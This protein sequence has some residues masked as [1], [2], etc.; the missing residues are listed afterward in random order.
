MWKRRIGGR[1]HDIGAIGVI[2]GGG[3][4]RRYNRRNRERTLGMFIIE[5]LSLVISAVIHW[6]PKNNLNRFYSLDINEKDFFMTT[7]CCAAPTEVIRVMD[8]SPL[9]ELYSYDQCHNETD[10]QIRQCRGYIYTTQKE[11]LIASN[12]GYTQ[13]YTMTDDLSCTELLGEESRWSTEWVFQYSMEG[14]L[15]RLFYFQDRWHLVTNKKLD[16]YRSRWSSRLSFGELME[17]AISKTMHISYASFL[18]SLDPLNMYLFLLRSNHDTRIVC[19]VHPKMDLIIFLGCSSLGEFHY[20][21]FQELPHVLPELPRPTVLPIKHR[22]DLLH[23]MN[24][25]NVMQY[26]GILATRVGQNNDQIKFLHP[27][28][29]SLSEIRGNNPNLRYRYLELRQDPE[30]VKLLYYLYPRQTELF[31]SMEGSLHHLSRILYRFYVS[32]YMKNQFITLPKEEYRVLKKCHEYYLQNKQMNRIYSSKIIDILNSEPTLSLYKMIRRL[33]YA[34][35]S[36]SSSSSSYQVPAMTTL[37]S[38]SD[39]TSSFQ[40]QMT[41]L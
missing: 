12:F 9:L 25:I 4:R 34:H 29:A 38:L 31:D 15:L 26:Q 33:Q 11:E 22:N 40:V 16:A 30:K 6:N 24:H 7:V 18:E 19:H 23:Y 21:S 13:V 20:L 32:R 8:S 14:T 5:L 36:S 35:Y 27:Q 10:H 3:R 17:I 37:P 1:R 28:Y 2:D 39:S 41:H